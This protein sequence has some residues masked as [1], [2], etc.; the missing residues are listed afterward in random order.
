MSRSQ[1]SKPAAIRDAASHA[2]FIAKSWEGN[3]PIP[4]SF[5]VR[6]AVLNPRMH[7]IPVKSQ[8]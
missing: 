4:Q 6:D 3:L 7:P 5:P 8:D 1:D 2:E